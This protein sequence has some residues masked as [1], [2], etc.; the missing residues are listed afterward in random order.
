MQ[1]A[2]FFLR[3]IQ[4]HVFCDASQDAMA[5]CIYFRTACSSGIHATFLIGRTKVAPLNQESIPKLELQAALMGARLCKFASDEMRL[6]PHSTHFWTDS[7]TVLSWIASP[8]KLK[9]YCANR[10][11]EILTLCKADQWKHIP[12]RLNPADSATRGIEHKDVAK[13]WLDAP[14]ILLNNEPNWGT[15]EI[16]EQSNPTTVSPSTTPLIDSSR[17]SDWFRLVRVTARVIVF[18][19]TL[20][21]N[22]KRSTTMEDLEKAKLL[23]YQQS[24]CGRQILKTI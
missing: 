20:K 11:G 21:G 17:F 5:T 16:M 15:N 10:V 7:T 13:L 2:V 24:L 14:Q 18:V 23:L 12:V 19:D 8:G 6:K 22:G 3:D 9:T 4:L 1:H